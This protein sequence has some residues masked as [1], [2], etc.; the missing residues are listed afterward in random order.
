MNLTEVEPRATVNLEVWTSPGYEMGQD[1]GVMFNVMYAGPLGTVARSAEV[2]DGGR[3]GEFSGD[4][5]SEVGVVSSAEIRGRGGEASG[6]HRSDGAGTES[7][8]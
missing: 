1:V 4:Q 8:S 5:R 7:L 3:G 6:G 2:T